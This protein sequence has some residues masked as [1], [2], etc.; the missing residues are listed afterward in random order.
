[1]FFFQRVFWRKGV[2]KK[3]FFSKYKGIEGMRSKEQNITNK[4]ARR[5]ARERERE[6]EREE[7]DT[8]TTF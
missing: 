6:R 4:I 3:V 2:A 5:L 1:M 8:K 7:N